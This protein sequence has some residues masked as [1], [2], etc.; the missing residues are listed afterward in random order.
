MNLPV[1]FN[2]TPPD[3]PRSFPYPFILLLCLTAFFFCVGP[4]FGASVKITGSI[5]LQKPVSEIRLDIL[6]TDI[7]QK[8]IVTDYRDLKSYLE[9]LVKGN[10]ASYTEADAQNTNNKYLI[11]YEDSIPDEKPNNYSV[12]IK[13]KLSKLSGSIDD[14]MENNSLRVKAK[15][16]KDSES[17][18]TSLTRSNLVFTAAPSFAADKP[19]IGSHKQLLINISGVN[20]VATSA[21][22]EKTPSAIYAYAF[23]VEENVPQEFDLPARLFEVN[24]DNPRLVSCKLV[25]PS[26]NRGECL[27][28]CTG[29][30]DTRT[31]VYLDHTEIANKNI[32][33]LFVNRISVS[34]NKELSLSLGG[35]DNQTRYFVFLVYDQGTKASECLVGEPSVNYT[36]TELNGE[37]EATVV[38]LRCFIASATYGSPLAQEVKVFRWFRDHVLEKN[39]LGRAAIRLY[40]TL[41]PTMAEWVRHNA[42]LRQWSQVVL[43]TLSPWIKNAMQSSAAPQPVAPQK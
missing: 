7:E 4:A 26:G 38:D 18:E 15:Y 37:K 41:S 1:G 10:A 16:K 20:T 36:L 27:Q 35:L 43:G 21:G 19:I 42:T 39:I 3:T 33:N 17:L 32:P 24:N 5:P 9:I 6:V 14:D 12:T 22:Q 40:N 30:N 31:N 28:K 2:S 29:E 8:D 34:P 23:K 25:K 11:T 13:V